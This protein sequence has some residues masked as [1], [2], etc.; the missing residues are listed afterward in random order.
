MCRYI[1][2]KNSA[3]GSSLL[4]TDLKAMAL[5]EQAASIEVGYF[6][7]PAN[8]VLHEKFIKK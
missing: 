2:S 8:V 1:V 5:F 4:P 7:S 3:S 6:D